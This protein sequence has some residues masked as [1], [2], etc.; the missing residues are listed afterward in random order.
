MAKHEDQRQKHL[1]PESTTR[2][3]LSQ[4]WIK[5]E[6]GTKKIHGSWPNKDQGLS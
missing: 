2:K 5:G 4:F 6:M 1:A 3:M